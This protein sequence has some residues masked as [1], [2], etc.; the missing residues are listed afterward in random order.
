MQE[1]ETNSLMDDDFLLLLSARSGPT[2]SNW[3][4]QHNVHP[5]SGVRKVRDVTL[6]KPSGSLFLDLEMG[7]P[8]GCS[9]RSFPVDSHSFPEHAISIDKTHIVALAHEA[10]LV[11]LVE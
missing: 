1:T 3:P 4:Y 7:P 8:I 5:V 11:Y 6:V 2:G 9:A 10:L